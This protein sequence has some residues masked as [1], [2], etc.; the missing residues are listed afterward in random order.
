MD[1]PEVRAKLAQATAAEQAAQAVADKAQNGARPQE[2]EMAR[3]QWQRAE[4][5]A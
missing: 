4:T 1:S 3:M 2:I 5:A